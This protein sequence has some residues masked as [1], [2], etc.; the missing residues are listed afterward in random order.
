MERIRELYARLAELSTEELAELKELVHTKF[1]ELASAEGEANAES[2]SEMDEL[3]TAGTDVK[4]QEVEREQAKAELAQKAAEAKARMEELRKETTAGDAD[5][6][7][8][9]DAK[10]KAGEGDEAKPE[11]DD[12]K[13]KTPTADGGTEAPADGSP[14]IPAGSGVTAAG[15]PGTGTPRGANPGGI[16]Q[17]MNG[18]RGGAEPTPDAGGQNPY[19]A[20][21]LIAAGVPHFAPGTKVETELDLGK[22]FSEQLIRLKNSHDFTRAIVASVNWE[23]SYPEE[24]RLGGNADLNTE[25]LNAVLDFTAPRYSKKDG[26]LVATG[27]ICSPVN[28]D[29]SVPTWSTADRPL[30]DGL[31]SFQASRGGVQYVTPPDI[32]VAPITGSPSGAGLSTGLWSEATDAA[33]AGATKPVWQVACGSLQ[34]V[35]VGA[36]TTRVQFGNMQSRFAPEQVAA[37]TQQAMAISA[38]EAEL[39]LLSLLAGSTKQVQPEQFLGAVRDTLPTI[40]LVKAQYIQGHRFAKN[41]SL[42]AIFPEWARDLFRADL[43]REAAHD[44]AGSIDVL[45]ITDAQIDDWFTVR[46]IG[47]VIWTLDG[48]PAGT[49]GTGGHAITNQEFAVMGTG[50][51]QPQWPGQTSDGAFMLVWFLF[52]EGT[53]QF[54]DGGRLDLGVV[55]DSLLDATNDYETFVETFE[56]VAFRGIDAYQVQQL[57]LPNGASSGTVAVSGYHE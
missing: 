49:Y 55:R 12:D 33:P 41:T 6:E 2:V 18:V 47:N 20:E 9:D 7:G 29:Y 19:G 28:V 27:G 23:D 38:R 21:V 3:I 50:A 26:A 45:A 5:A 48:L 39:N 30:R 43:A 32:G 10:A 36:I 35:E 8:D 14:L 34:T 11:G 52:V 15:E 57:V 13:A 17:A 56:S 40:D 1:D 25:R 44:N 31:P 46:G 24:R 53:F 51:P 22:A 16:I 37:N 42:T 4:A 54:L